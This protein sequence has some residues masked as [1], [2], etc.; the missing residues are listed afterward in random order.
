MREVK[1]ETGLDIQIEAPAGIWSYQKKDGQFLNGV[2]FTAVSNTADVQLS[3]EHLAYRWILPDEVKKY[4]LHDS[5]QRSLSQMKQFSY[6]ESLKL[7]DEFLAAFE[8]NLN[9]E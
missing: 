4:R 9:Y 1:E 6:K 7:L 5:L 3:E 8:V 2:I